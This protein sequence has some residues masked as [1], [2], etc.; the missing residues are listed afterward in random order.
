MK[1]D[2]IMVHLPCGHRS[3]Q[4]KHPHKQL[5]FAVYS[6]C[7]HAITANSKTRGCKRFQAVKSATTMTA[8]CTSV[9]AAASPQRASHH[10][11]Q[12]SWRPTFAMTLRCARH[13]DGCVSVAPVLEHKCNLSWLHA[14]L[15]YMRNAKL[16]RKNASNLRF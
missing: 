6:G 3:S 5:I 15:Q 2:Q 16:F 9:C 7:M 1:N 10:L 14:D 4:C 11:Q 13:V 12:S 8:K